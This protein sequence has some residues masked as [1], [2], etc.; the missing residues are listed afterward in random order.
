MFLPNFILLSS[1]LLPG[2]GMAQ[3]SAHYPEPIEDPTDT[4]PAIVLSDTVLYLQDTSGAPR[5]MLDSCFACLRDLLRQ[6][7][8]QGWQGTFSF[9]ALAGRYSKIRKF[10]MFEPASFQLF[11]SRRAVYAS[12]LD[13][14]GFVPTICIVQ[15]TTVQAIV[16]S[17][18]TSQGTTTGVAAPIFPMK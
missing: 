7:V 10:P 13:S 6:T 11:A 16:F 17:F 12:Y 5:P 9:E 4:L 18:A 15:D 14:T 1:L 8:Q 2:T 3:D